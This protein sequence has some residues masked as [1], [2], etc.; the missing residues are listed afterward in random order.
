MPALPTP[1]PPAAP[2]NRRHAG[3]LREDGGVVAWMHQRQLG[4]SG[5]Q[6]EV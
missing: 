2:I 6:A 3:L 5:A 4:G 1:L